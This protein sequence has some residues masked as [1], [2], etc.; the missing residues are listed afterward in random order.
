MKHAWL[1]ILIF[2]LPTGAQAIFVNDDAAG[3][4]NGSSWLDAFNDLQDALLVASQGDQIWVAE[5]IYKPLPPGGA[6][7]VSF[8]IKNGIKVYGGFAGVEATLADRAGLFSTTI[9]SGDLNGDDGPD[10]AGNDENS[11]HVVTALA[12]SVPTVLDGFVVEGGN[13]NGSAV[14][15]SDGG[16]LALEGSVLV[17]NCVFRSNHA[18]NTGGGVFVRAAVTPTFTDCEFEGNRAGVLGAGLAHP[19][20]TLTLNRCGFERNVTDGDGG[21]LAA[22]GTVVVRDCTFAGNSAL[23]SG[24]GIFAINAV[25][26]LEASVFVENLAGPTLKGWGGGL[27]SQQCSGNVVNCLFLGNMA[28]RGGGIHNGGGAGPDGLTLRFR[29]STL[30]QNHATGGFAGGGIYSA[31]VGV[32]MHG[33][34]LWKNVGPGGTDYAAQLAGLGGKADYCCIESLDTAVGASLGQGNFAGD[35][36]FADPLGADGLPGTE[37]DDLHLLPGSPCIDAGDT[38]AIAGFATDKD[39]LPRVVDDPETPDTGVGGPP[40]VDIGAYEHRTLLGDVATISVSG[41]GVQ[42]LALEA[43][44]AFG[45]DLYLALG[46]VSG[47][48]P[49]TPH[50]GKTIPLNTDAYFLKTLND[51]NKAPL[52]QS[53]GVLDPLGQA[54][55]IFYLPPGVDSILAGLTVHH[56]CAV[57]D[58]VSNKLELVSNP[59][60]VSLVP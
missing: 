23:D 16:G 11:Y 41:G 5:G 38:G 30:T 3:S 17:R 10:F 36:L 15:Q 52:A 31:Q 29:N 27:A 12:V 28:K 19:Q 4:N 51:P 39:G 53:F 57:L 8:F 50:D 40:T 47:T 37:D 48:S 32:R 20:G 6:R 46:S 7:T 55:A 58:P 60:E 42:N 54:T 21:G 1:A 59:V 25:L 9:L 44:V 56:A 24:G 18:D 26:T 35:P 34:V 49:G 33:V 43:G 22:A 13:A 45:G 14:E 2:T